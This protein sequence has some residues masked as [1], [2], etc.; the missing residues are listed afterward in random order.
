ME[1]D[2]KLKEL[3][4]HAKVLLQLHLEKPAEYHPVDVL[5]KLFSK[6]EALGLEED[7]DG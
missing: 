5:D 1:H 7:T 6:F 4:L 3:G 2:D